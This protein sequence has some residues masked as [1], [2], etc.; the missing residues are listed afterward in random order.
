MRNSP[1]EE[2]STKTVR[3]RKEIMNRI[4]RENEVW[5]EKLVKEFEVS[6]ETIRRD[7]RFLD[8]RGLVKRVYG[9][10]VNIDK[11][12]RILPYS[13]RL[14]LHLPQ[15]IAIA[16]EAVKLLEDGDVIFMEGTTT[17]IV[18]A[19]HIPADLQLT[20]VTNSVH[21]ALKLGSHS[22]R[23]RIF[24]VGGELTEDGMSTGPKL[25]QEIQGYR[26]DK[27]FCSTIA[28]NAKGVFC[29]EPEY[30]QLIVMLAALSTSL[31]LLADSSK[32]HRS[33]F[34]FVLELN[35][36]QYLFTDQNIPR[37]FLDATADSSC[38]IVIAN[39]QG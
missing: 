32:I 14:N 39:M 6:V 24:M 33:A 30:Q 36:F 20:V 10:A 15:K 21:I 3:R 17:C 19:Q 13:V 5:V 25:F 8:S 26:F 34:L 22:K 23:C 11:S 4:D 38:Q 16:R 35:R 18:M 1:S 29:S 27:A 28:V 9:G 2:A 37:S 31:I 12:I 7:L